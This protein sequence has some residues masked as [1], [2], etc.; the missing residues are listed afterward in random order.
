M[1]STKITPN[2]LA[3][4]YISWNLPRPCRMSGFRAANTTMEPEQSLEFSPQNLR[5][6]HGGIFIAV[7]KSAPKNATKWSFQKKLRRSQLSLKCDNP[8]LSVPG[9]QNKQPWYKAWRP[10]W[11]S[12]NQRMSELKQTPVMRLWKSKS[13]KFYKIFELF[14][15]PL[16][17]DHSC[18]YKILPPFLD[19]SVLS[20]S[21]I[22]PNFRT[23]KFIRMLRGNFPE[24][25]GMTKPNTAFWRANPSEWPYICIFGA[26]GK[27][28]KT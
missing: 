3:S 25:T 24:V 19:E 6:L 2:T 17:P 28:W 1:A 12:I 23:A 16:M 18:L 14:N 9:A 8:F 21:P 22:Y 20:S 5:T 7:I 26:L 27:W 15:P 13:L 10:T 4:T 11:K